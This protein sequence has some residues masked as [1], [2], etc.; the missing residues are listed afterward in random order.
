M[1]ES[2]VAE[3]VRKIKGNGARAFHLIKVVSSRDRYDRFDTSPSKFSRKRLLQLESK[4]ESKKGMHES[5]VAEK[6]S[7]IKGYGARAFHLIKVVSSR[8][9]YDLF[10]TSPRAT[11]VS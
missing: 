10:D 2:R 4:L 7:K 5:R 6:V 3:K 1:H 8:D 11:G 9:R